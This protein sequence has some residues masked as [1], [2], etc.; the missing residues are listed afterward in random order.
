MVALNRSHLSAS[1]V[2]ALAGLR[3]EFVKRV[4]E[5]LSTW[6]DLVAAWVFG[7]VSSEE[8]GP[9]S[10]I[11]FLLVVDDP[12]AP[13]LHQRLDQLHTDVR[14]WTGNDL[15]VVEHSAASWRKLVRAKNPLVAQIKRDGISLIIHPAKWLESSP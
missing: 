10:D 5:Q 12:D 7:S 4:R 11:D 15:Q 13:D 1:A 3:G 2:L 8:G 14:L 6:P 9:D